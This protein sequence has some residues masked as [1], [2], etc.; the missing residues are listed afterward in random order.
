MILYR[1]IYV[2]MPDVLFHGFVVLNLLS[3]PVLFKPGGFLH[4]VMRSVDLPDRDTM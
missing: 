4:C 1:Y 3:V 2:I